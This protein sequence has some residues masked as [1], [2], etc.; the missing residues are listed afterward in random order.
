MTDAV[1]I[2]E[3]TD[4]IRRL[5][6]SDEILERVLVRGEVSNYKRYP[7]GH[8]YF[9]L[10]DANSVLRSV[11]FKNDAASL[12]FQ[13]ADGMSVLA[14]GRVAVYPRDGQYQLYCRKMTPD[15]A[16]SLTMAYEELKKKLEAEGLFDPRHK[17]P[18]PPF[19]R[20]VALVTSPAGA[21]VRDMIRILGRRWPLCEV[22]VAP[23]RVQGEEAPG[24]IVAALRY[25]NKHSVADV[26]VT[27]RGGGSLEDLWAFNDER[28]ARAIFASAI[29]VV[30][31]V[32]HEPDVTIADFV[33]DI[34]AATP[35]HAAEII[36]PDCE[37]WFD[38]L[39]EAKRK[40]SP[41]RFFADKRQLLDRFSERLSSAWE[42]GSSPR[43]KTLAALAARLDALSPLKV[44][45]RGYA[46]AEN[47]LGH[48]VRS[49]KDVTKGDVLN[50]RLSDGLV[51][52]RV[53]E[54]GGEGNG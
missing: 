6:E 3:L 46:A 25:C 5:F 15:G 50:L 40:L 9:T 10:K 31:A 19:P 18:L 34:R 21:A 7:S 27:G 11:M 29:P 39:S 8:H 37:E 48:P 4:H 42:R 51:T 49:V 26:I 54:I 12:A 38:R 41:E 22:V 23:V 2:S 16:G 32:G 13:P 1:S 44:L 43:G 35:S 52:S 45:A 53:T 33:A 36:A 20:R 14:A 24:E 17:K 30:S 47:E 28:V